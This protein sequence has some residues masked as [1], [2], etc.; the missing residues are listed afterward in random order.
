MLSQTTDELDQPPAGRLPGS[1]VSAWLAFAL[2]LV[3]L[4]IWLALGSG[5]EPQPIAEAP[6]PAPAEMADDLA[7]AIET[8]ETVDT[9]I[10]ADAAHG[11]D[12][13]DRWRENARPFDDAETRPLVAVVVGGLGLLAEATEAA[14]ND[15]PGGVTLS[16]LP[17]G[18]NIDHWVR[19]AR[20][21]GHEVLLDL[22]M[23]PMNYP[24][25]DPGPMALLTALPAED[26]VERLHWTLAQSDEIVGVA[27]HMG[28]RFLES[29]DA[30]APVLDDL[31][32]H[33]L[34]FLDRGA[35]KDAIALELA[36]DRDIPGVT[37]DVAVDADE[38]AGAQIDLRLNETADLALERG[39]AIAVAR[40]YPI[41]RE[42]IVAWIARLEDQG[43]AL[44]PV[45]AIIE[46]ARQE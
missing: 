30:L 23:E 2:F 15:L 1:L 25:D 32:Q 43:I 17:Y 7:G 9:A 20:E 35:G 27:T 19:L 37:A 5:D 4:L 13:R 45:S 38:L 34:L 31:K 26:N 41:S 12:K 14:I 11:E 39:A 40:P 44:A 10:A 22:P 16:F 36:A 33:G 29:R 46:R 8:V 3:G 28:S 6:L 42:R 21:A 18:R 24:V